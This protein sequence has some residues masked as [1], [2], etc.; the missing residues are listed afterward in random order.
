[1]K[2]IR[3]LPFS[4]PRGEGIHLDVSISGP[5]SKASRGIAM[6]VSISVAALVALATCA[7]EAF[8]QETQSYTY[9]VHGR[10]TAV[11]RTT[12]STAQTTTYGLDDAD[13]RTSRSVA[14]SSISAS[15]QAPSAD[16][17]QEAEATRDANPQEAPS[18]D[19]S[20]SPSPAASSF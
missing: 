4:R 2:S 11:T 18:P 20:E 10:L 17:A 13:N 7:S 3:R 16:P 5:N 1:M 14:A 8:A 9:D 12:A 15:T 19:P 6:R